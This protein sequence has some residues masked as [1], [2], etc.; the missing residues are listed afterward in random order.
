MIRRGP[1][2]LALALAT[3]AAVAAPALATE[4]VTTRRLAGE[5]RYETAAAIAQA[6]YGSGSRT[7]VLASG[8]RFPDALAAAYLNG[9]LDAPLLLTAGASL[10]AA[11]ERELS[12]LNVSGVSVV[13]GSAAVSEAVV[14]RLRQLGY[15]VDRLSGSDRYATARAI[16]TAFPEG[17]VGA[18]GSGGPT[19]MV[20]SG[21]DFPDAL[22]GAPVSFSEAFPIL[23]TPRNS[24]SSQAS[25]AFDELAIK[26]V[27]L[28]GGTAAVSA[29]VESAIAAKGIRVIRIFG[30]TRAATAAEVADFEVDNLGWSAAHVNLARG[31]G[32]ADALAGGP[33]EGKERAPVLLTATPGSLGAATTEWLRSRAA[34]VASIDALGGRTAISDATVEQA[35]QAATTP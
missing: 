3:S 1:L 27:V 32:F 30:N 8:E 13:G 26:Q 21:E 6:T 15:Q 2:A 34:T 9:R 10:S 16:A 7:A 28:L 24:L 14:N 18:L 19:A 33:H 17:F 31:D 12:A 23:L 25:A 35:R 4:N 22:S 5:N 29:S 20:A 11:T